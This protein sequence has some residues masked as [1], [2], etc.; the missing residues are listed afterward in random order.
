M[1]TLHFFKYEIWSSSRTQWAH[2]SSISQLLQITLSNRIT[3]KA[4]LQY[5]EKGQEM[6]CCA[7]CTA[8]SQLT[9]RRSAGRE[10][11]HYKTSKL[12]NQLCRPSLL[13][14]SGVRLSNCVC[15]QRLCLEAERVGA[16]VSCWHA[17]VLWHS[18]LYVFT[19]PFCSSRSS[20]DV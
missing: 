11:T 1:L 14:V 7:F 5:K 4:D 16:S 15:G 19:V 9:L 18:L 10:N 3:T 2:I 17:A 12:C 6:L 8:H 13:A 20:N